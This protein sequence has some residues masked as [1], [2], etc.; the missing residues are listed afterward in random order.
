MSFSLHQRGNPDKEKNPCGREEG[1]G[2]TREN[3]SKR[4]SIEVSIR[5]FSLSMR[6][7]LHSFLLAQGNSPREDFLF[8]EEKNSWQHSRTAMSFSLR[9]RRNPHE[10]KILLRVLGGRWWRAMSFSLRQR[11]NPHEEK[12]LVGEGGIWRSQG[13]ISQNNILLKSMRFFTSSK[14]KSSYPFPFPPPHEEIQPVRISS[15]AKRK[16]RGNFRGQP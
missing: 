14:R 12:I 7:P 4:Y 13:R 2:V 10:R 9:Q 5:V 16:T 11:G 8:D 6:K 15:L 3:I 1:G